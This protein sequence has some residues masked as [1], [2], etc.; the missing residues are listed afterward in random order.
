MKDEALDFLP[1]ILLLGLVVSISFRLIMPIY[2]ESQEL[3]YKEQYDKTL[4]M[5]VGEQHYS[6]NSTD[7]SLTYEEAILE[8]GSQSYFMPAPR[9]IDV[10]GKV[11]AIQPKATD[12]ADPDSAYE[13]TATEDYIPGNRASLSMVKNA[14]YNW[15]NAYTARYSKDGFKLKF[16]VRFT[17]G[18][19]EGASDD[20]YSL[21]IV[22]IDKAGNQ[23]YLRCKE[24]GYVE[25]P[26][27]GIDYYI[28]YYI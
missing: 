6:N 28:P 11:F 17:T 12:I 20:C 14:M 24:N 3:V 7:P 22:A 2:R 23:F 1:M 13:A 4:Q 15:C 16:S 8:I 18:D 10:G 27:P 9:V 26:D 25:T 19:V 5:V 21:F